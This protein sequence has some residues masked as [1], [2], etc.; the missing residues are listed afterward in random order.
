MMIAASATYQTDKA[1]VG[2]LITTALLVSLSATLRSIAKRLY[3]PKPSG[4]AVPVGA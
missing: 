4:E 1:L 3:S 2:F